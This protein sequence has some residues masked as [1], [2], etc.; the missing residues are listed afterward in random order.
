MDI[1][2]AWAILQGIAPLLRG[3]NDYPALKN[4]AGEPLPLHYMQHAR[5]SAD[6]LDSVWKDGHTICT[7]A[8]GL[9]VARWSYSGQELMSVVGFTIQGLPVYESVGLDHP[10]WSTVRQGVPS[11]LGTPGSQGNTEAHSGKTSLFG[12]GVIPY[13]LHSVPYIR[14]EMLAAKLGYFG[15]LQ[16][17]EELPENDPSAPSQGFNFRSL[18]TVGGIVALA[19]GKTVPGLIAIGA[20]VLTTANANKLPYRGPAADPTAPRPESTRGQ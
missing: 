11:H 10:V 20:G 19:S 12:E 3:K 7:D 16:G 15:P 8:E 13:R 6:D 18:L 17:G 9:P 14:G 4:S 5:A 1:M 2:T